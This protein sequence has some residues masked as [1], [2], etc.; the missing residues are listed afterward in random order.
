MW[1]FESKLSI[2]HNSLWRVCCKMK[3]VNSGRLI[4]GV[5]N[6]IMHISYKYSLL[7]LPYN[8]TFFSLQDKFFKFGSCSAWLHFI[9]LVLQYTLI[10]EHSIL[11]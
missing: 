9:Y 7:K 1:L 2:I 6:N 10:T 8:P 4:V 5:K 3:D 11:C